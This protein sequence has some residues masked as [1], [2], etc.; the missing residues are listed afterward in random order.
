[1][2][3]EWGRQAPG[4]PTPYAVELGSVGR[5]IVR[6]ETSAEDSKGPE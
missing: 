3:P 5:G 2:S 4:V 1:M 6:D